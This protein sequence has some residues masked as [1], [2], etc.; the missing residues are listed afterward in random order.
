[1]WSIAFLGSTEAVVLLTKYIYFRSSLSTLNIY[2]PGGMWNLEKK[3]KAVGES[4]QESPHL[5]KV[6]R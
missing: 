5:V 2:E 1:M 6:F 4:L 3:K